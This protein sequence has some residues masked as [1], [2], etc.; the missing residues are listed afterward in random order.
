MPVHLF[1]TLNRPLLE[2]MLGIVL[3]GFGL[4][5]AVAGA[6]KLYH[7]SGWNPR[8]AQFRDWIPLLWWYRVEEI[9]LIVAACAPFLKPLME[10]A[11]QGLGAAP[12][13][14]R[15]IRLRTM[16]DEETWVERSPGETTSE[17]PTSSVLQK[18]DVDNG[19]THSLGP[20]TNFL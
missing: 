2:R 3:M 17:N 15:T 7:I 6:L 9:G 5:A 1:W 4:I 12:F 14:F 13:Q 8:E 18:N 16:S 10:R 20:T 11:L 19:Q